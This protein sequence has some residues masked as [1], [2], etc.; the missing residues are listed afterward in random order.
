MALVE[1]RGACSGRDDALVE[2]APVLARARFADLLE[3]SLDEQGALEGFEARS[4]NG[5]PLGGPDF[6]ARIEKKLGRSV[7]PAR[8]GRKPRKKRAR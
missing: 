2:V 6:L 1:R 8:P 4:R 5:R 7:Q 3:M